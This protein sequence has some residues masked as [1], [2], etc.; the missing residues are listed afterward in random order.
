MN[1]LF[2]ANWKSN[3]NRKEA[4]YWMQE[5]LEHIQKHK[6]LVDIA[7]APPMCDVGFVSD[8][9][10]STKNERFHLCVQDI[11]PFPAGSYTGAVGTRN[12]TGYGIEFAIVGHSERRTYFHESNQEI[13]NKVSECIDAQITPILCVDI[14]NIQSQAESLKGSEREKVMV[15]FEPTDHIGTGIADT[16]EDIT[17]AKKL[18]DA[19]FSPLAFLYGGSVNTHTDSRI[20][21]D[22]TINGYIVGTSSLQV[23]EFIHILSS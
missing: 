20:M 2:I 16:Y 3:K 23:P 4:Q 21:T 8:M 6:M 19:A 13:A 11:S 7:I 10:A 18:I 9:L 14:E 5:F 1:K 17:A 15:A 22:K 12:L